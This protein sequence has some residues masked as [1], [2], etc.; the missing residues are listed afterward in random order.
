VGQAVVAANIDLGAL[1]GT[2]GF[3]L[4]GPAGTGRSVSGA[5]DVN[6]DGFDDLIVGA[7]FASPNALYEAGQ[8]FVLFG[9]C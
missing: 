6:G 8:S 2:D 1:D 7:P 5:G 4:I 9:S 3:T